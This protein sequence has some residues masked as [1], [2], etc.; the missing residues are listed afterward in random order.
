MESVCQ[1]SNHGIRSTKDTA[2]IQCVDGQESQIH[3]LRCL[4]LDTITREVHPTARVEVVAGTV[5]E[6]TTDCLSEN[7]RII[8]IIDKIYINNNVQ[9]LVIPDFVR[10]SGLSFL[11]KL[12]APADPTCCR[13]GGTSNRNWGGRKFW[14]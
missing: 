9:F 3:E 10:G 13:N 12:Q 1:P 7:R 11:T 4:G 2:F 5:G 8:S 6:F 14:T